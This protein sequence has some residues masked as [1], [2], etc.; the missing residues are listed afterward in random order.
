[1]LN[2][3]NFF[4]RDSS[5]TLIYNKLNSDITTDTTLQK[6]ISRFEDY[7]NNTNIS[8]SIIDE[9]G[10][11]KWDYTLSLKVYNGLLISFTPILNQSDSITGLIIS[12]EMSKYSTKF[13]IVNKNDDQ[14]SLPKYGNSNKTLFTKSTYN[15]IINAIQSNISLIT[16]L[17]AD[18]IKIS[19]N[20]TN[21]K[22]VNSFSSISLTTCWPYV[23]SVDNNYNTVV[24]YQCSTNTFLFDAVDSDASALDGLVF[25]Y[26][27][28]GYDGS[29]SLTNNQETLVPSDFTIVPF[30]EDPQYDNNDSIN[31]SVINPVYGNDGFRKMGK[32]YYYSNGIVQN[33]TNDNGNRYSVFTKND[34][35]KV[36]FPNATITNV[37]TFNGVGFTTAN[38]YIHASLNFTLGDLEREYGHF[39]QAQYYGSYFYYKY[40][41]LSSFWNM[42]TSPS[43]HRSFWTEVDANRAAYIFF[44]P[45]SDL[46]LNGTLYPR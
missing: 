22:V 28:F 45:I 40:I 4:Q 26:A 46:G 5:S 12:K 32:E 39:L 16:K 9:F 34:G 2:N 3:L 37:N 18:S 17:N 1:M 36:V 15:G 44:G 8:K 20:N 14:K 24:L 30:W 27:G 10:F 21:K 43:T 23:I 13:Y 29:S 19:T 6:I 35:T 11:P 41:A 25:T 31:P 33:Y 42:A 7:N 38:G